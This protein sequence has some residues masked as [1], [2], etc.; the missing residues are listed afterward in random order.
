MNVVLLA[1]RMLAECAREGQCAR[2]VPDEQDA[3]QVRSALRRG[4]RTRG[5]SIRTARIDDAVVVVRTD[6]ALW[7]EDAATMRAKLT[8]P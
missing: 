7:G 8:P 6:A 3:A 1:T 5:M 2:R 4:A